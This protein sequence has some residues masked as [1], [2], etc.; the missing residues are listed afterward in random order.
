M[1]RACHA[2]RA[3]AV[4][5]ALF[6]VVLSTPL[7]ARP[8]PQRFDL[9]EATIASI[10]NAIHD[11]VITAEKLVRMYHARIAAYDGETTAAHLNAYIHLNRRALEEAD[12][13]DHDNDR[14]RGEGRRSRTLAGIPMIL[15]DNIDTHD[16][17]TTAGSLAFEDP[18]R[19]PMR[20]SRESCGRPA[21]SSSARRR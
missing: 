11:H 14:D 16:M 4:P 20:S 8:A 18:S 15:K 13:R 19:V 5:V 10:Q 9:V 21:R 6:V 1:T 3:L 7:A 17:P 12:E 2:V